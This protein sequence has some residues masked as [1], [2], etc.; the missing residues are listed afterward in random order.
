MADVKIL[1]K[2]GWEELGEVFEAII[3]RELN[4]DS[5]WRAAAQGDTKMAELVLLEAGYDLKGSLTGLR[6]IA[7]PDD[8]RGESFRV[9]V[10][11]KAIT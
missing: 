11:Y 6:V 7:I 8:I 1:K 4:I 3:E 5:L 10:K 2:D 9:W